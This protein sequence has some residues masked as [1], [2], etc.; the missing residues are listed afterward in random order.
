M[1]LSL[2]ARAVLLW[3]CLA[4]T[5][6]LS[7]SNVDKRSEP[8]S[9]QQ[10]TPLEE[11]SGDPAVIGDE[12]TKDE[13]STLEEE[14]FESPGTDT[15]EPEGGSESLPG[16]TEE[17]DLTLIFESHPVDTAAFTTKTFPVNWR[18][19]IVQ[20]P[21]AEKLNFA[22]F[23]TTSADI[24]LEEVLASGKL[25]LDF[26][27]GSKA[28]H[29]VLQGLDPASEHWVWV[30]GKTADE[31]IFGSIPQ[32]V[33]W[34]SFCAG[35]GTS[36]DPYEI[37][38]LQNINSIRDFP[39]AHY[40][41]KKSITMADTASWNGGRG[42][43]PIGTAEVPFSG[44][45]DGKGH[46]LSGLTIERP[47]QD[48]VGLF[49][50]ATEAYF[51]HFGLHRVKVT[52]RD[53]TGGLSGS[54]SGTIEA[55]WTSGEVQGA[56]QV[57]GLVGFS[58][59]KVSHS[60]SDATVTGNSAFVGGLLGTSEATTTRS[61]ASGWV[62]GFSQVGGLI[63]ISKASIYQSF[64]TGQLLVA[65]VTDP[66]AEGIPTQFG[67]L[68]GAVQG[69]EVTVISSYATVDI[70]APEATEVG[71]F[72]GHLNVTRPLIED[73][74][75]GTNLKQVASFGSLTGNTILGGLIGRIEGAS[76]IDRGSATVHIKAGGSENIGTALGLISQDTALTNIVGMQQNSLPCQNG[77]TLDGQN[78][79]CTSIISGRPEAKPLE[80]SPSF[81]FAQ[82][83]Q[84]EFLHR[85]ISMNNQKAYPIEGQC[86]DPG[87]T[88]QISG[89]L[90]ATV[91][92]EGYRFRTQLDFS[93]NIDGFQNLDFSI[94]GVVQQSLK[95]EKFT[96]YCQDRMD[97]TP[98]AG[99]SGRIDSPF[100]VCSMEQFKNLGRD[101]SIQYYYTL[102][103]S[104]DLDQEFEFQG[105]G[106]EDTGCSNNLCGKLD[107]NGF[108]ISNLRINALNESN[109]GLTS[110][111]NDGGTLSGLGMQNYRIIGHFNLGALAGS[112]KG[113]NT[114]IH[115]SWA[116]GA[117]LSSYNIYVNSGE[118]NTKGIGGLASKIDSISNSFSNSYVVS[119]AGMNV[120]GVV[121]FTADVNQVWSH[122]YVIGHSTVGN[123]VG[124]GKRISKSRSDGLVMGAHFTGGL[125]GKGY[126][127]KNSI[128]TG[129]LMHSGTLGGGV[130]GHLVNEGSH[131]FEKQLQLR[132]HI[133]SLS[134]NCRAGRI[135]YFPISC[136]L[137]QFF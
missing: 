80:L 36:E 8:T 120:A 83:R 44:H 43:E 88:I 112:T 53:F 77:K 81:Q 62:T 90:E 115:N 129:T 68:A 55:V 18:Q 104:F 64:A 34:D 4:C 70:H 66:G 48:Q 37:C 95:L 116:N 10:E 67:G 24:T 99:G 92:C 22:V 113:Y 7:S 59:S 98:F 76:Y 15:G 50:V 123:I 91:L 12:E 102:M 97:K 111:L 39:A 20:H 127:I 14:E 51:G 118:T 82:A 87:S 13:G 119:D 35:T 23:T 25:W 94:G 26:T 114:A 16:E 133:W 6:N 9:L 75:T 61:F 42:F 46:T 131:L 85:K 2:G 74:P 49:G 38:T 121:G 28:D 1:L 89:A 86:K 56:S 52:G 122:S 21:G 106:R 96:F 45:F 54:A 136:H 73:E 3:I 125:L 33:R 17:V 105:F 5:E 47:D 41:L 134:G 78:Y 58:S 126:S 132:P 11:D 65:P 40:F 79:K 60:Y 71:G 137:S 93:E 110:T 135:V 19:A 30:L 108:T 124:A 27:E 63:G 69:S 128:N 109:L 57:G 117:I 29:F 103:N 72:I 32:K 31:R 107:G 100:T 130:V 101:S 84:D